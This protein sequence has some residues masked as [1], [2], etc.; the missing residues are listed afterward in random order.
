[1]YDTLIRGG[2]LYDGQGGPAF[3]ADVAIAAGRIAAIGTIKSPA[4][5]I[6]LMRT[7]Q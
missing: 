2:T 5:E 4:R 7:A 1:M 3:T 6:I